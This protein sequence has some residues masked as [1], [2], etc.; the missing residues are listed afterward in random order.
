MDILPGRELVSFERFH[1]IYG[2]SFS[3]DGRFFT[4]GSAAGLHV[5]QWPFYRPV[6]TL[7]IHDCNS[8]TFSPD[9]HWLY[10]AGRAAA[11]E[12][13]F[14]VQEKTGRL[15]IGPAQDIIPLTRQQSARFWLAPDGSEAAIAVEKLALFFLR[16]GSNGWSSTRKTDTKSGCV[17]FSPDHRWIALGRSLRELDILDAAGQSVTNFQCANAHVS[18]FSPDGHWLVTAVKGGYQI[19][20]TGTWE[21]GPFIPIVDEIPQR[22]YVAFA[23]DAS[24]V[25]LRTGERD[26]GL[27]NFKSW[28]TL[29]T[30]PL[31]LTSIAVALSPDANFLG[32]ATEKVGIQVWDLGLVRH[33]LASMGLDWASD[34]PK[35]KARAEVPP[36]LSPLVYVDS[37]RLT[38]ES[39]IIAAQIPARSAGALGAWID[40]SAF[41]NATLPGSWLP[42]P[43]AG[44]A[45]ESLPIPLGTNRWG[46]IDF[47]VRG[48]IQLGGPALA[49]RGGKFPEQVSGVPI[50]RR[51]RKIHLLVGTDRKVRPGTVLGGF[52]ARF[53]TGEQEISHVLFGRD[54]Y[55]WWHDPATEID[56]SGKAPSQ[57]AIVAWEGASPASRRRNITLRVYRV[58]WENPLW[59]VPVQT[60]DFFSSRTASSPFILA[61][62]VE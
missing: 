49:S 26:L 4:A 28:E 15:A 32:V 12:W 41:Y 1:G 5:W 54:V 13:P 34:T 52:A 22:E 21:H 37:P 29:A 36:M 47:D 7:P 43:E 31:P 11:I 46:G 42:T 51:C 39:P 59:D 14:E 9:G 30:L 62:T 2:L 45:D 44:M 18:R 24:V 23:R 17:D 48:V 16:H 8:P 3:P 35:R 27:L 20:K 57:T 61:M 60:L 33:G 38:N 55:D 25:V 50:E 6:A 56:A 53:V 58:T 10:T 40:L 19:V